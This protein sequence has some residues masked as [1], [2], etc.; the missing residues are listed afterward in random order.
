MTC[1][2]TRHTRKVRKCRVRAEGQRRQHRAHRKKVEPCAPKHRRHHNRQNALVIGGVWVHC[3]HA[4]RPRHIAQSPQ[5]YDQD[6]DNHGQRMASI[7]TAWFLEGRNTIRYRLDTGHRCASAR[8]RLKQQIHQQPSR[9]TMERIVHGRRW[10]SYRRRMSM[11]N[12]GLVNAYTDRCQQGPYKQDRRQHEDRA[13]L[14]HA[15]HVHQRNPCQD[16]Q[17]QQ[18]LVRVQPLKCAHQRRHARRNAHRGRQNVVDHQRRS[19]KQ[20][21]RIAQVFARHRI[22]PTAVRI[23]LDRLPIAEIKDRQQRKD[24]PKDRQQIVLHIGIPEAGPICSAC[25]SLVA[26]GR[27]NSTSKSFITL[28]KSPTIYHD[29]PLFA[30]SAP[31]DILRHF[32]QSFPESF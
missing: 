6:P 16:D 27:P 12:P 9:K 28:A 3:R 24:E 22:R 8:K 19:R 2:R 15:A 13:G 32:C 1:N 14:L 21:G 17:A 10:G 7:F 5:Q 4:I 11:R 26:N 29:W 18:Q 25:S 31:I 23:R 30:L 20:S